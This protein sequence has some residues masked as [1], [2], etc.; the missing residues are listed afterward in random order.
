MGLD[1]SFK[2]EIG[3]GPDTLTK[4][5]SVAVKEK[6]AVEAWNGIFDE[7]VGWIKSVYQK[8][9]ASIF[10]EEAY[11]RKSKNFKSEIAEKFAYANAQFARTIS[12]ISA[13]S[14]FRNDSLRQGKVYR[15]L[16]QESDPTSVMGSFDSEEGKEWVHSCLTGAYSILTARDLIRDVNLKNG[17]PKKPMQ[18]VW[19]SNVNYQDFS[20]FR[21]SDPET[22]VYSKVDLAVSFGDRN[23]KGEP[24]VHFIQL[25]V[26]K[27]GG[28][29]VV[30][31]YKRTNIEMMNEQLATKV[32]ATRPGTS[33]SGA[34][35]LRE[36]KEYDC[37]RMTEYCERVKGVD[38]R[39]HIV[40]VP[41]VESGIV[42]KAFGFVRPEYKDVV[43]ERFIKS[44]QNT[45]F[46]PNSI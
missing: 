17:D 39:M 46:L 10:K 12:I 19:L 16:Y 30:D 37:R 33:N 13:N 2:T 4:A 14:L 1:E 36:I 27:F 28:C 8:S 35:F 21:V 3:I 20:G 26:D 44:A 29:G 25:K 6:K 15:A 42:N 43:T 38:A 9:L 11:A 23:K 22:D 34:P 32:K 45:S 7:G 31:L 40:V 5:A 24:I 41:S 18:V